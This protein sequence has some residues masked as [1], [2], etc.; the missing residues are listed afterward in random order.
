MKNS[1]RYIIVALFLT[2]C[3]KGEDVDLIVHNAIIHTLADGDILYEAM[4]VKDG[5]IVELGPERQ[6]LNKYKA[7]RTINAESKHIYPGLIDAHTHIISYAEQKL[8]VNLFG[9]KTF[10]DVI[11]ACKKYNEKHRYGFVLGRG[12]DQNLWGTE[13]PNNEL[14]NTLFPNIPV[15][16]T[17]VDGH[18]VLVNQYLLDAAGIIPNTIVEG[19]RIVTSSNKLTGVLVDKAIDLIKAYLPEFDQ[20]LKIETY[21]KIQKELFSF[22]ITGVHE[23]GLQFQ[24]IHF[25]EQLIDNHDFKINLYA[26]LYGSEENIE[27]AKKHGIYKHNNLSIRSFKAL[28][29]GA[30]GSRGA[31]LKKT[32]SDHDHHGISVSS[33]RDLRKLALLCLKLDYQLNTHCIG[34]SANAIVLDLLQK[35]HEVKKDHRFRIEHAQVIDSVD[36]DRFMAYNV[37][38]SVQP[39]HATS[40]MLWAE[41]RIGQKRING[42]YA[43]KTLLEKSGL[44]VLGTDFPVEKPNPFLTIHAAVQRKNENN[45]PERGYRMEEKLSLEETLKGMTSWPAFASFEENDRGVLEAGKIA[46]FVIFLHEITSENEFKPNFA[47]K[48]FLAGEE[49][50]SED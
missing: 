26:M 7:Q 47:W 24:D 17:R 28:A 19:G 40:D 8:S 29:D 5:R 39:T 49:V 4:A 44:I 31:L 27:F 1:Y 50:Y 15:C 45:Q 23:A 37:I 30:L 38:P 46:D 48:T 35:V 32:Y 21:K 42:A 33:A 22:G 20:E 16:L 34:D 3:Y 13:L 25:F 2:S 36:F 12:W 6:I 18:A 11:D 41:K 10:E 9:L 14:L 43:Y